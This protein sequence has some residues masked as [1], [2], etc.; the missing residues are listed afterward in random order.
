MFSDKMRSVLAQFEYAHTI[1]YWEDQG[2][3]FKSH[4]HV[5]ECHPTTGTIF[6]EREDEGHVFKV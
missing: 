4:L 6:C 2:V 3:P 1:E 5:P